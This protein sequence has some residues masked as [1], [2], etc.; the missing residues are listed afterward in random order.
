MP[1][2]HLISVRLCLRSVDIDESLPI[3][4]RGRFLGKDRIE[5]QPKLAIGVNAVGHRIFVRR[6]RF[7]IHLKNVMIFITIHVTQQ[8]GNEILLLPSCSSRFIDG[9]SGD[10][11][12]DEIGQSVRIIHQKCCKRDASA[13]GDQRE[14]LHRIC[15]R[16]GIRF[17]GAPR[18]A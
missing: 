2:R 8:F 15:L 17:L 3:E 18:K 9:S 12:A 7:G 4:M 10:Y 6:P 1:Q 16:Y 5:K 13:E 14:D 11:R